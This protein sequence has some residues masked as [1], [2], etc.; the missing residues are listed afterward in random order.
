MRIRTEIG[1]FK[2]VEMFFQKSD[3]ISNQADRMKTKMRV[4]K[5]QV[6]HKAR[7]KRD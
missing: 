4:A 3:K 2:P 5:N 7:K 6:Q 1:R